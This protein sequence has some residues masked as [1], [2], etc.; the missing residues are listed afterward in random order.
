LRAIPNLL[1]VRPAD[2]N[3]T[4]E[5]WRVALGRRDGPV[6]LILTRQGLPVLDREELGGADGLR[7]GAYVLLDP[8]RGKPEALIL[9]SGSEVSLALEAGRTLAS[10]GR[11]VRVVSMP[12]LELFAAESKAYR[13]RVLPPAVR[14][15][16]AIEAAHP[17]PWW[18]WVGDEGDVIGLDHFG[19]SAP[20]K[21]LYAEFG[22]T[23]AAVVER[24]HAR[25]GA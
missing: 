21:R 16:V 5:A 10:E 7:R 8:P 1:V 13:D 3:E 4:S 24:V 12:C 19:A 15:R 22:L 11:R 9:A 17:Q 25:L 6:A 20:Y 18:R 2:A 14:V 23:P